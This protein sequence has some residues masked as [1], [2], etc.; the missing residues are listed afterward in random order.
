MG[1][2]L[3]KCP[4]ATFINHILSTFYP[5]LLVLFII[6]PLLV[7]LFSTFR[8]SFV[9]FLSI[10][11]YILST[12]V[13]SAPFCPLFVRLS[14]FCPLLVDFLSTFCPFLLN[15]F[16]LF[17]QCPSFVRFC[18]FLSILSISFSIFPFSIHFLSIN[19]PFLF[20]LFTL[21]IFSTFILIH[22]HFFTFCPVL[23]GHLC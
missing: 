12:F 18:L 16:P 15:F 19:C 2:K 9:H 17:I 1:D 23:L 20:I 13:V 14:I 5:L 22:I 4:V 21:S 10:F 8:R 7:G 6:C 3:P 11:V